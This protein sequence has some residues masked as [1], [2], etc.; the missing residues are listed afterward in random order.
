MLTEES[1]AKAEEA[2]GSGRS[3]D[4]LLGGAEIGRTVSSMLDLRDDD[5]VVQ[6]VCFGSTWSH[7][8]KRDAKMRNMDE[9]VLVG[10]EA[11][12]EKGGGVEEAEDDSGDVVISEKLVLTTADG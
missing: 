1:E 11:G 8:R 4:S 7:S 3:N 2:G 9:G 5:G 6:R 12:V 10:R